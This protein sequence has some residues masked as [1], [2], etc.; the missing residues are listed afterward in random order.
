MLDNCTGFAPWT[1]TDAIR[2][3]ELHRPELGSKGS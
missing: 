3:W 1:A 2:W